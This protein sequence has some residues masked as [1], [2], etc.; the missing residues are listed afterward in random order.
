M[1]TNYG[2]LGQESMDSLKNTSERSAQVQMQL[3][4][5]LMHRNRETVYGKKYGFGA[6]KTVGEFQK[7]VPLCVYGDYEDYILR[8]IAGE[9][10]VLTEEPVV[11]Y[12]ISSG[13]TGNAK[14]LPLTETDLKIQY[15]YAYGVPFG[16]I[17]DY[18]RNLPENEVFGKIFQI[19]EFAKTYMEN[20]TMNGIRSGC[21]YQW[22][23]RDGQ[24]DAEDYCVPKEVLF[25][26]TLEDLCYVKVRFALAEQDLR[27]IHGVFVNRVA[28]V[29]D[30]ICR[31]WEMLLKDME[32]GR[33][34]ECVSLS[35]KW[36]KYVEQKLPPN[37]LRAAQLRLLSH[38]TLHK[39]IIKKIWPRVRYVLAIGG[40]S[41]AY[42]T[43]KMQ[44]YAGDI[45]IHPYAYAASE[46][47]F[48]I[49][50][51]MDQTDRYIL[52]PEAGFFEFL[53][54][55][56]AQIEEK[57]PLFMWE[58]NIGERYELVF[59]NHSGLYRYC[60]GDV[61]EVVDWYGQAPIVQFCYRKNQV[62][63]I[64]G[65]KSNLEQLTEAVRQFA[66]H[67]QCEIIG[68]CVQEDMSDLLPRYQFH[69][70]CTDLSISG[71][72][73]ILD[74]C[75]CRV[76]YEYQGCRKM[77]EIG[78]VR[79]SYLC[80]GSFGRYEEQ[81]AKNGKMMGQSKQ[82]CILDTEEKKQFFAA[83]ENKR[84]VGERKT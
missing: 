58:I 30:Y 84:A 53:P 73:D 60:M 21:V 27:A 83:R 1:K 61:I 35:A 33:V 34:D 48:G 14:Y 23:D 64:A 44:E 20:G 40:K 36:R 26:D 43:E 13:T 47:I 8:M 37:P 50:E 15:T 46:G 76:N 65:E 51:K 56:E 63:N 55:N 32:H 7:K 42:Y 80:A 78:K 69:L 19:G 5:E 75:L 54:L 39:G 16:M 72:E 59:T 62:L 6:I 3:L 70:E 18:Y 17:K 82:V 81:L 9:E 71:A 29:L 66:L 67:M 4:A 12:C 2:K 74:E 41:F 52:F 10:K 49:A 57:R 68:Y 25:P 79:I 24:F 45:P 77:N 31:N 38:D 28:G 22:L 11:Y